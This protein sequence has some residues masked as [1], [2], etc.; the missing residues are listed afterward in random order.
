MTP[1]IETVLVKYLILSV[2]V[3]GINVIPAFMPA[4]WVVLAFFYLKYHL[5]LVPTVIIGA[6]SATAGRIILSVISKQFIQPVLS[7]K[8]K[9]NLFALGNF[10]NKNIKLAFSVVFAYA[11]LPIP[12]NQVFIAAGLANVNLKVIAFSFLL[13]R[14]ISYTFWISVTTRVARNLETIFIHHY[15]KLGTT[16]AE[17]LSLVLLYAITQ[18][19]W[20][21]VLKGFNFGK[22]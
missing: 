5:L 10:L 14:L 13:G 11:F 15:T 18:I 9:E 6:L 21:K 17:I 19:P 16:I 1:M 8:T 4:T 22:N 3:F 2:F 20:K 12:S 7:S